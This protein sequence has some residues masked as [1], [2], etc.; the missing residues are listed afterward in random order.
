MGSPAW[1]PM[2]ALCQEL[3]P[4]DG[5]W[6]MADGRTPRVGFGTTV[7]PGQTLAL[8][9]KNKNPRRRKISYGSR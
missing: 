4:K 2:P 8:V 9:L 7:D 6:Q 3:K 5:R 1:E